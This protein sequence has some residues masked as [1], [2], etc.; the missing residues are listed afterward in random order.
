MNNFSWFV[1]VAA[2]AFL[3]GP[4]DCAHHNPIEITSR[5]S[6]VR[7]ATAC[8]PK[9]KVLWFMAVQSYTKAV[10][11][12]Y[13]SFVLAALN[14]AKAFAPSLAPFLIHPGADEVIP[15]AV[16]NVPGL[17]LVPHNLTFLSNLTNVCSVFAKSGQTHLRQRF[18]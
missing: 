11:L 13:Y 3:V 2:L 7:D 5:N 14:S 15:A 9:K 17:T 10:E 4:S 6:T 16:R 12:S 18:V 8:L 1:V